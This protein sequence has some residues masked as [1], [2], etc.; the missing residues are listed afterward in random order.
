MLPVRN[1]SPEDIIRILWFRKWILLLGMIVTGAI[2]FSVSMKIPNQYRS[3]TVILVIPQRVPE[4]YV[5]STVTMRIEDRLRSIQQEIFSRSRL[6]KIIDEFS[7]Y[8]ELQR[9]RPMESIVE[10]MRTNINVE[11]VRD[12]AFKVSFSD[13]TP[14]TA[15]I[16]TDRLASMFIDENTRDRSV[17]ADS[18]NQF[19][20]SQLEDARQR[21]LSHERKLEE[22]R[23]RNSG[24]LP[25]QLQ[26]NLQV[27]QTTNSQLQALS[28]SVNRDRDRRLVLE[29]SIA[30]AQSTS[31]LNDTLANGSSSDSPATGAGRTIDQLEKAR[32]ELRALELRMK[33][34]HPDVVAKKRA[35]A[36]LERKV[37]Q[38]AAVPGQAPVPGAKPATTAE[39]IRQARTHQYQLEIDKLDR[40]IAS[41][42]ADMQRLQREVADYQRKVE[43]VPG[44]ESELTDLM[45]DYD[46]LQK[47]YSS[48]LSKKEDSK[49][50]ANLE[51]Q[52]VSE[53]FKI[54]D[55]ARLPQ[56]PYSPNRIQITAIAAFGGLMVAIGIAALME[57]RT[58]ALRTEDEIVR[59]LVLPVLA[60]IPMMT[61]AA[62]VRRRRRIMIVSVAATILLALGIA[63]VSLRHFGLLKGIL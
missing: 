13:T 37:E 32:G 35:I 30:D 33:P 24:E 20:E 42:D 3:E 38:E 54:L 17:M 50:S 10:F 4:S 6:E 27:I 29:R 46:T 39:L 16:V 48:L 15:M 59:A 62:D 22:F 63:T 41:K 21:L 56:R 55:R 60:A 28:E 53:Q 34:E 18:T 25:S 51:R 7:L 47:I 2:G 45:R 31:G 58:T 26:T 9:T 49:I 36:E 57:Y 5:H 44:H 52:Q 40:Q 19:L 8:P 1:Y 61:A 14:R 11:T 12:D 43:A 23:R